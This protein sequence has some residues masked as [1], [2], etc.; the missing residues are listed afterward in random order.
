M[1]G[2]C[3]NMIAAPIRSRSFTRQYRDK[4]S[5]SCRTTATS[6]R[7]GTPRAAGT[8]PIARLPEYMGV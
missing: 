1:I 7:W 2:A 4:R 3:R 8:V 6:A 5:P